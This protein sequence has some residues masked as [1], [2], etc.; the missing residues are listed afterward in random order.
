MG[1][2]QRM[3]AWCLN[4]YGRPEAAG[5][6][7]LPVPQPARGEVLIRVAA[8]GLNPVDYKIREGKLRAIKRLR[9][10][11]V[12]G[13]E[14]AGTVVAPGAGAGR[15]AAGERVFARVS[16]DTL[17][18]FAG[19]A[20]V[21]ED[22]LATM[23]AN[24]DFTQAAAVPLAGLT[25]LQGLRDELQVRPGMRL[26]ITGG[27]G[28]VGGFALQL[29]RRFGA[30]VTTTASPRG[31]AQVRDLGADQVIDYTRERLAD[32]AG[33]FDACF[34]L[35]GGESLEQAFATV[36]PGGMV[37]SI[38]GMPEPQTARKDLGRG[39]GLAL[40]FWFAS[41]RLRALAGRHRVRYRYLFMHPSGSE[42]AELADW[43]ERRELRVVV[44]R[45]FPFARIDEA[46]AYLETGRAKGK[47]VVTMETEPA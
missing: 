17:G 21:Q 45:L 42:L 39:T 22:L 9:L 11:C 18:A 20:C 33:R 15:F 7:D 10:P 27:A 26:L 23:P 34:D 47:V 36:K 40:L 41:R 38:A 1:V 5:W 16:K 44:D 4:R 24:L 43:I 28:G 29:A 46:F 31:E 13:N 32:Y 3:R 30:D 37:L 12:L 25:A 19:Y 8:A 35:V 2:A 14:L 6:H